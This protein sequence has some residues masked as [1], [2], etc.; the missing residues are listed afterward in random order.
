MKTAGL[1][2]TTSPTECRLLN[3]VLCDYSRM[4]WRGQISNI[5]EEDTGNC[6]KQQCYEGDKLVTYEDDTDNCVTGNC[7]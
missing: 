7:V 4:I 5:D 3:I 6:V 2:S 1:M